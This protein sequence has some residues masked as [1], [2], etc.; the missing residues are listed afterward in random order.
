M[1]VLPTP[2]AG[3]PTAACLLIAIALV[4]RLDRPEHD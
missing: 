2:L 4:R 3:I 1:T